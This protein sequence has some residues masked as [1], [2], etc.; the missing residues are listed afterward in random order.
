MALNFPDNPTIGQVYTDTVSGFSYEW[1][2]TVWQSYSAA[3]SSNISILDDISGSFN[4]STDTFALSISGTSII[5][6]NAQQLRVVLGGVVQE[7]LTDYTVSSSNII[8]STPPAG[9]LDCSIISLGPAV[10]VNVPGDG[11]VTP[12]KL[13]TGGPS[14]NTSGDVNVS[15]VITATSYYGDGSNLSGIGA[16]VGIDTTTNATFYPLFTQATSGIVTSTNVADSKLTFNPSLGK[17][18]ATIV[19]SSSD[20]NLK[21]DIVTI[22]NALEKVK[23]LRGVDFIWKETDQKSKGGIAQE[24]QKIFPELVSKENNELS[25]NYNGLIAVLIE[26]IKELSEK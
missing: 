12:V 7:P 10:P 14:W 25:V 11:T 21:K 17:L 20:E 13:S 2:G 19:N 15:G 23:Q 24:L 1:D 22:D 6:A 16:T 3:S 26:A 9:A 5:P 18:T 8:F 4:G